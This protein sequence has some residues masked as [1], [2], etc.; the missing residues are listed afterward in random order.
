MVQFTRTDFSFIFL[1]WVVLPTID[2][3]TDLLMIRK[4]LRGPSPDQNVTSGNLKRR[5]QKFLSSRF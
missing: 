2:Q 1:F 5:S 4:L 3:S